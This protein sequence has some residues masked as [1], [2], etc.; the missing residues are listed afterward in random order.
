[1]G[2]TRETRVVI[3]KKYLLKSCQNIFYFYESICSSRTKYP[4]VWFSPKLLTTTKRK[5]TQTKNLERGDWLDFLCKQNI[6]IVRNKIYLCLAR[7][8][9]KFFREWYFGPTICTIIFSFIKFSLTCSGLLC[10][11]VYEKS[12]RKIEKISFES[13]IK[14]KQRH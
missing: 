10:K 6:R 11:K 13:R 9:S 2:K 7:Q 14:I 12:T 8:F 4:Q 3:S 5:Q 1:M